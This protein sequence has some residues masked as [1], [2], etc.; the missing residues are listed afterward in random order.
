MEAFC[1][2]RKQEIQRMTEDFEKKLMQSTNKATAEV[3]V[4]AFV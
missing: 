2:E 3:R 1:Q 4:H